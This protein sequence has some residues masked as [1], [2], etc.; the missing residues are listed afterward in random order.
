M[1]LLTTP[2]FDFHKVISALMTPLT[3]PI[4]SLVK[5]SLK[6][7]NL[8][9]Q[10]RGELVFSFKKWEGWVGKNTEDEVAKKRNIRLK[11]FF[12]LFLFFFFVACT[13]SGTPEHLRTTRKTRKK[14]FCKTHECEG[15]GL[16]K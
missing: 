9:K 1:T 6:R 14:L 13:K 12:I 7:N 2:I 16:G 4:P 11:G 3:I 8:S 10:P 5:T 15:L